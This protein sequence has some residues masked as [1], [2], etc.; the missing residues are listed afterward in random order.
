MF[1]FW[2]LLLFFSGSSMAEVIALIGII[3]STLQLVDFS[4]KALARVRE[5]REDVNHLPKSF[6]SLQN[7][8]LIPSHI[9]LHLANFVAATPCGF[10]ALQI[11]WRQIESEE[12]DEAA[13]RALLPLMNDYQSSICNLKEVLDRRAPLEHDKEWKRSLKAVASL[14]HDKEIAA[15]SAAL[16][17]SLAVINQYH[18]AYTAATTGTILR[19]LTA[20]V[21]A[22]PEKDSS[23][24]G[25]LSQHFIV[26]IVW[27]DE[28]TGR[29]ETL[30]RMEELMTN[31]D[32]HRRVAMIGLGGVGKTRV[33]L[34]YAYR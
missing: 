8:D 32:Q 33:L 4:C 3:A 27:S 24:T 30:L 26:P 11:T 15:I 17:Q 19:K 18:G 9:V 7:V 6:T 12:L 16:A 34:Q 23:Q 10:P 22:V 21:A 31:N 13:C 28:F 25:L 14:F 29:K 2:C 5:C 20:A 1:L